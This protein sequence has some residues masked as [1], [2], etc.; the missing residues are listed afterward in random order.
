MGWQRKGAVTMHVKELLGL[1]AQAQ[2]CIKRRRV[3]LVAHRRA[4]SRPLSR[5]MLLSFLI[6]ALLPARGYPRDQGTW[7]Q[8]PPNGGSNVRYVDAQATGSSDGS[9]DS[10]FHTV[11]EGVLEVPTQ[12]VV[13][14][15]PG[16]YSE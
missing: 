4:A 12:G 6:M 1:L 13:L 14:L 8:C 10:P 15:R 7:G 3:N 16:T 11:I 2:Q 9:S 5:L